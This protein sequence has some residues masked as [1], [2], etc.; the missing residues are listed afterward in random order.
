MVA[1]YAEEIVGDL[2]GEFRR[3]RS[4]TDHIYSAFIKH[5]RKK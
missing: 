2:Q 4:T 1:P 3:N 5:L